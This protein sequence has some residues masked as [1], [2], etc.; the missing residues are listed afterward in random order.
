MNAATRLVQHVRQQHRARWQRGPQLTF[1]SIQDGSSFR[2]PQG[3]TQQRFQLA[4]TVTLV[5][6]RATACGSA[7][8]G[9]ASMPRFDL[10]VFQRRPH[11]AR[12]GLPD[13]D[14]NGDGKVDDNDLLFAVTLRSGKPD[15]ALVTAGRRQQP[16][17]A[18]R[19]GRL[20]R[21]RTTSTLN[22]GLRYEL[23]TDVKNISRVR[24]DQSDRAAVPP[25]QPRHAT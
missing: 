2:V 12:R 14:H 21:P 19:A 13:F 25:R 11:R 22:L 24:R 16:R 20:A 3:T 4:D 1:P 9:S 18:V 10:G 5:T 6:R 17:R 8:S 7:A 23:D 15:Q